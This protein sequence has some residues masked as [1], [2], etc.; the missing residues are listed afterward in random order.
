M[1]LQVAFLPLPSFA[2]QVIV[3][4][5]ADFAVT[6]PVLLTVAIFVFDDFQVTALF[7]ALVGVT[8]AVNCIVFPFPTLAVV[9]FNV[10]FVTFT[11]DGF[12][13]IGSVTV[14][15]QVAFLSLPSFAIQVILAVP[16]DTAVTLPVLSTVAIFVSDEVQFTDLSVA[17]SGVMVAV[18][19]AVSPFF[20]LSV[21]CESFISATVIG[22]I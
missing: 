17:F 12:D 2:V 19:A 7:V 21:L 11:T 10:I 16:A 1:T 6:L 18:S 9:L 14:T 22:S 15:L 8:V 3:T 5:P 20:I 13:G 4:V